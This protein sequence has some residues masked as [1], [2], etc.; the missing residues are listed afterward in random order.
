MDFQIWD[1]PGQINYLDGSFNV[2]SIF[3]GVGGIV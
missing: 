2:D 3:T 1:I